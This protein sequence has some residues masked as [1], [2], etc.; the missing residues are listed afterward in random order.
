MSDHQ[1][2]DQAT[3]LFRQLHIKVSGDEAVKLAQKVAAEVKAIEV[4]TGKPVTLAEL[5]DI[6]LQFKDKRP[7]LLVTDM[8]F[9]SNIDQLE[10]ILNN[11]KDNPIFQF[12]DN[13]VRI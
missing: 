7:E 3:A 10:R 9:L 5:K 12:K 11:D 13:L 8:L 6:I 4:E 2:I 1:I